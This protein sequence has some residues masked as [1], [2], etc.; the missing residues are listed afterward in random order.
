MLGLMHTKIPAARRFGLLA[1]LVTATAGAGPAALGAQGVIT[2]R[3]TML[4]REG[5][6]TEDL[7]QAVVWLEGAAAPPGQPDTVEMATEQKQFVPRVAVIPVGS[8]VVFPNHDPFNHN[9]FSL[10]PEKPFDL[11]LFGR[12]ESRAVTFDRPGIVRVYCNVH[13]LMRAFVLVRESAFFT[14]PG[15]DG[16]FRLAPVPPGRYVLHVWHER[17][18]ELTQPLAVTAGPSAPLTLTL[19]AR[20]YKYV[21]HRDKE[22]K[23]YYE[24]TSRY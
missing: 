13:A 2:G 1:G 4:E 6:A 8:T 9:V 15:S 12:G 11:G 23:S 10:S 21:Q 14:Q 24:R 20:G 5:R 18:R 19:D 22:G 3:V 7:A 17:A 16:S